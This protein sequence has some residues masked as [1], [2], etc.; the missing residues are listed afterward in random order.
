VAIIGRR[1][2]VVETTARELSAEPATTGRVEAYRADLT[3]PADTAAVVR[4]IVDAGG[5]V[6]AVVNNAGAVCRRPAGDLAEVKQVWTANFA[7]NVLT[8]VLLTSALLP[9]LARPGG[10]VIALGSVSALR[11][12][13]TGAYSAAKAALHG[14]VYGL[15]A[16]L[17]PDGITANIVAPGYTEGTEVFDGGLTGEKR[18]RLLGETLVGRA[19]TPEEIAAAVSYLASAAAGF[20]TGTILHVNGGAVLGR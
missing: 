15:A 11:G 7:S 16:E 1:Q 14:W 4:R 12:R 3:D 2:E 8:A 13:S 5:R 6:D 10:R 18:A 19:G 9:Y 17:G 20:V